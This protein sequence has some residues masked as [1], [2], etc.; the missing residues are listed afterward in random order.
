MTT[1]PALP[2]PA[3]DPVS[4]LEPLGVPVRR[5]GA[6]LRRRA[7]LVLLVLLLGT[8]SMGAYLMQATPTYRAEASVL[9]EPHRTQVSDL[10]AIT[11]DPSNA[12]LVRT[13]IDILRSPALARRVVEQLGLLDHP[14]FA[15]RPS[16]SERL[17]WQARALFGLEQPERRALTDEERLEV[18]A[19]RLLGLV[20]Q[21]N[22]ARSNVLFIWAETPD[23]RLS[24]AIAN[25][26][27]REYLEFKRRQKYAAMQRAH[28]WF[29][30]RLGELSE[31]TRVA[32]VAVESY[33]LRNGLAEVMNARGAPST[34]TI[35]RQQLDEAARQLVIVSG[36]KARKE[37]QLAQAKAALR[38]QRGP[39]SLP[40]VLNSTIVQRLRDQEALLAAREAELGSNFGDR[41]PD[42]QAIRSQRRGL[43][44]RLQDEMAHATTGLS[45]EVAA[46]GAQEA[47]LRSR[48]ESLRAAVTAENAAEVRL[49]GLIAEANASRAIYESF[50]TRATQLAN[51]AGIQEPD[52]E[53]VTAAATPS[54]PASPRRG[55]LLACSFGLSLVLGIALA[56]LAERMGSGIATLET[57]EAELGLAPLGL[58]PAVRTKARRANPRGPGAADFAAAL[59][60]LRGAFQVRSSL[61]RPRVVMVTSALPQEG[62]T[63]LAAGLAR[64]A[65]GA[66]WRV[67]LIDCD[68]RNPS[69][70]REIGIPPEPGLARVLAGDS[71]GEGLPLIRHVSAGLDVIPSGVA[72]HDPQELL[73]SGR[74]ARLLEMARARYDLVIVDAPPV[75]A[76]A[77][78]LILA[79]IVDATLLAVR[80][81]RTPRTAAR[82]ALRLL[83]DSHATLLGSVL[84]QVHLAR[85]AQ[86]STGGLATMYRN[87][88]GYY[89]SAGV[90]RA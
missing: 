80:W 33:R 90:P 87:Y 58:L 25:Q 23:A 41:S 73:A 21:Q 68:L 1:L 12:N 71:V 55:R 51:V 78:A 24:A 74:L 48:L 54:T 34:L 44:Q 17:L 85:F 84:T 67:C 61:N 77:D 49:Q 4:H 3:Y 36:E 82:D 27:A 89:R 52:A 37:A 70:A 45:N 83:R 5:L 81:E 32:E 47:A 66:G 46:A 7:W 65:A 30:E 6:V 28:T 53:L 79:G 18:A 20:G 62:K 72:E 39:E 69:V 50:L 63:V 14:L 76:A 43:Q 38:L 16:M 22:E 10:Q 35:N 57:L 13:Q 60:R 11:N 56:C 42:L 64:N 9:V 15:P 19:E 2:G 26:L 29:S 86:L 59:G 75:L 88:R 40:E 31:K 8:G